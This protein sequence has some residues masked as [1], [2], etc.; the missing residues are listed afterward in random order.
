[1]VLPASPEEQPA[2]LDRD[3]AE[4]SGPPPA[5]SGGSVPAPASGE[6]YYAGCNEV[7]AA[8]K[9][10]LYEGQPGYRIEMSP[11]GGVKDSGLGHKEGVVEAMKSF[12]TIRTYSLPW[13][14]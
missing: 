8:G 3:W 13:P 4:R 1:M 11:F 12:T 6:V 10:P 5:P 2:E 7:R 9:A 14:A